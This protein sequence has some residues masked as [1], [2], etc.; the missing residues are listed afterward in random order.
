[1]ATNKL[2]YY[3]PNDGNGIGSGNGILHSTKTTAENIQLLKNLETANDANKMFVIINQSNRSL[4]STLDIYNFNDP[5]EYKTYS[6]N[7][8]DSMNTLDIY[9]KCSIN[10]SIQF[11]TNYSLK[12]IVYLNIIDEGYYKFGNGTPNTI[13]NSINNWR[14]SINGITIKENVNN[15]YYQM[16]DSTGDDRIY[17]KPGIYLYTYELYHPNTSSPCYIIPDVQKWDKTGKT[18]LMSSTSL[19]ILELIK[20]SLLKNLNN[21]KLKGLISFCTSATNLTG[22][23]NICSTSLSTEDLLANQAYNMC[24]NSSGYLNSSDGKTLSQYC[25]TIY[26]KSDL[27]A[28]IKKKIKDGFT[29]WINSVTNNDTNITTYNDLLIDYINWK[30]PVDST[31]FPISNSLVSACETKFGDTTYLPDSG[32]KTDLCHITYSHPTLSKDSAISQSITRQKNKIVKNCEINDPNYPT[33]VSGNCY[34]IYTKYSNDTDIV[35]SRNKMR[36]NLCK[37]VANMG[38]N[39]A[40]DGTTNAYKC[41]DL[42]FN[43]NQGEITKYANDVGRFC[44]TGDNMN[45]SLCTTYYNNIE[46][47]VLKELNIT[48]K[49]AFTNKKIIPNKNKK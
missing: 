10:S 23:N 22:S 31:E 5:N 26:G 41:S 6:Y 28:N 27:N 49:S 46:S 1:M 15:K 21:S 37:L 25:K 11:R 24:F 19:S 39:L 45:S 32:N 8:S 3:V 47:L 18:R 29:T 14:I 38:T 12:M 13:D 30:N 16:L 20:F 36:T 17:L 43:T 9:N 34:K 2:M 33:N 4:P 44:E 7:A 35:S 42:I 48:S 40:D